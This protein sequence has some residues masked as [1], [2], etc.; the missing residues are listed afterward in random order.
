MVDD[1][2]E[3]FMRLGP[4]ALIRIKPS[5]GDEIRFWVFQRQ[6]L[7]KENFPEILKKFPKLNPARHKPYTFYLDKIESKYY[8]GLQVNKDPG[9]ILVWVGFFMIVI[10]L[11]VTFFMSHRRVW[12]HVSTLKDK[13]RISVAGRANK[14][15]LGLERE[16]DQVIKSLRDC[17]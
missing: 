5:E 8:T 16:L 14:N 9:V 7:I 3:D 4:A 15:H 6:D 11:F 1:I 10:G 12:V 2:R 13:L 17:V